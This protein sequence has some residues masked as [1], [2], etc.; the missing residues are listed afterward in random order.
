MPVRIRDASPED[1]QALAVLLDELGYPTDPTAVAE[2]MAVIE[3]T[4]V[5]RAMVAVADAADGGQ[6]V[7]LAVVHVL[8]FIEHPGHWARLAALVVSSRSRGGGVGK[9][10]VTA[11]EQH[12]RQSGAT[13][14]E[15]TSSARRTAAH[16]F[17]RRL[18]YEEV[19]DRAKRFKRFLVPPAEWG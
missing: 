5:S 7:G 3:G 8:P 10:L 14:V 4:P 19:G 15:V 12:A 11:V 16:D 2:R 9:A 17:Y 18:G 13:M 1:A 6:V